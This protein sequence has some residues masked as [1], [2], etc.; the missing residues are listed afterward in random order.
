MYGQGNGVYGYRSGN[1]AWNEGLLLTIELAED[2]VIKEKLLSATENTVIGASGEY[3][4]DRMKQ[5]HEESEKL[6]DEQFLREEWVRFCRKNRALNLPLLFGKNR[7][8]IKINRIT[9]NRLFRVLVP[10][11]REMITM[12]LV[13]CDAWREV[14]TTLLELDVYGE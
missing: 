10:K 3:E 9:K 5:F 6:N 14:L 8:V 13:R 4:K 1:K 2:T 11:S 7:V 12:N